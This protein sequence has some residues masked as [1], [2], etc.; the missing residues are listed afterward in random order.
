MTDTPDDKLNALIDDF[1]VKLDA[2]QDLLRDMLVFVYNRKWSVEVADKKI[3]KLLCKL[4]EHSRNHDARVL[5][6]E[7]EKFTQDE[8]DL[9]TRVQGIVALEEQLRERETQLN[10][11]DAAQTKLYSDIQLQLIEQRNQTMLMQDILNALRNERMKG[12]TV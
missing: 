5:E 10:E 9:R 8:A 12:T 7:R 1:N 6:I 4:L 2:A 11:R 3:F